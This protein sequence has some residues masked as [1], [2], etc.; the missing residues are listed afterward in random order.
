M[1]QH[2]FVGTSISMGGLPDWSFQTYLYVICIYEYGKCDHFF[3]AVHHRI[4]LVKLM[5]CVVDVSN[6]INY[7][8]NE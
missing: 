6:L 3:Y 4:V 7:T 2:S 5:V 1:F 8:L